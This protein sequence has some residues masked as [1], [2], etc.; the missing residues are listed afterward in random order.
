MDEFSSSN[1]EAMVKSWAEGKSYGPGQ[2]LSPFRLAIV[3]GSIGPHLFDIIELLGKKE[4]IKRLERAL[5]IIK[6]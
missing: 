5:N 4:T 1:T 2:V 6:A 3:G